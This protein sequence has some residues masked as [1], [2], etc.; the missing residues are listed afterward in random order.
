MSILNGFIPLVKVWSVICFYNTLEDTGKIFSFRAILCI[1]WPSG[2][3][4]G[5]ITLIHVICAS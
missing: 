1:I 3:V 4:I 2:I 5:T